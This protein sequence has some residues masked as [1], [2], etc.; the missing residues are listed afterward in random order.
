MSMTK[1][2]V[3]KNREPR[4]RAKRRYRPSVEAL[5][6]RC[7]MSAPA[8]PAWL[9]V[10]PPLQSQIGTLDAAQ[11]LN[12]TGA[13]G[14]TSLQAAGAQGVILNQGG[15]G[16]VAWYTFTLTQASEVQL[17]TFDVAGASH[18]ESVV[19][20]Y[21]TELQDFNNPPIN[22]NYTAPPFDPLEHRL[23]AQV[24]AAA[25]GSSGYLDR[26]LA[27]GTYYVAVS[28]HGDSYFN[29]FLA[30]SGYAGSTGTYRLMVTANPLNIA[31]T[32]GPVVLAVDSGLLNGPVIFPT[33]TGTAVLNSAPLAIY[34]DLSSPI[35]PS[36]VSLQQFL[37]DGASV[38][39]TYNPTGQFGNGNDSPVLLNGFHYA[40]DAMELQLQPAA[41]LAPGFYQLTLAGNS[42]TGNQVL[43]D[44][45]DTVDLG[46]NAAN[47][48]GQDFTTTFRI[49]A[50]P[51]A[52][53]VSDDTAAT[54]Q[55]FGDITQSGIV[56]AVG[57]IGNDPAY[58][59]FSFAPNLT[60]PASQVDLYE[61]QISG[62][63]NHEFSKPRPLPDELAPRSIPPSASLALIRATRKTHYSS[64]P[65]MTAAATRPCR[66]TASFCLS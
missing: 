23:M 10:A 34:V 19:L 39:L 41:P 13:P 59:P 1:Q 24:D 45:T 54:A 43:M 28:G 32:D 61:F 29:P 5:E 2:S 8:W 48:T 7:L 63:G 64:S 27:A 18:L 21:D 30:D 56:Q 15:A 46:Q 26:D 12:L 58:S 51:G 11:T 38:Q 4:C 31:P 36:T 33:P 25:S 14:N 62:P 3:R 35:D 66:A 55:R 47:P 50:A 60:N 22:Y 9:T 44:P 53:L 42:S 37:G 40:P 16:G 49:A 20:L 52:A 17:A 65:P 57:A 6:D